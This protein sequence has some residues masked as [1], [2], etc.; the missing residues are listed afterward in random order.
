MQVS[1]L[2]QALGHLRA[3][4]AEAASLSKRVKDLSKASADTQRGFGAE[5]Q[6]WASEK[7]QLQS[8][9]AMIQE[10]GRLSSGLQ[11]FQDTSLLESLKIYQQA[12]A[13]NLFRE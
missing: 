13:D 12:S 8:I 4:A 9:Q 7:T 2:Q 11:Q 3:V 10:R 1:G 6:R 5:Q